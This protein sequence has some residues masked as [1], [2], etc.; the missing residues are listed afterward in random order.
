MKYGTLVPA[1]RSGKASAPRRLSEDAP[2]GVTRLQKKPGWV[3]LLVMAILAGLGLA[4]VVVASRAEAATT[5]SPNDLYILTDYNTNYIPGILKYSNGTLTT[6]VSSLGTLPT[7]KVDALGVTTSGYGYFM[8]SASLNKGDALTV[9]RVDLTTGVRQ[10]Y[11]GATIVTTPQSGWPSATAGVVDPR[12]GIYY[13]AYLNSDWGWDLY[14]FNTT[15][16]VSIGYVGQVKTSQTGYAADMAFDTAGNLY[17]LENVTTAT[18]AIFKINAANVPTVAVAVGSQIASTKV[19]SSTDSYAMGLAYLPNATKTLW[20]ASYNSATAIGYTPGVSGTTTVATLNN[21][22]ISDLA[23]CGQANPQLSLS[24]NVSGR[25]SSTDQFTLT[26]ESPAS[27]ILAS[28]TTTG[29]STGV[30]SAVAG[31]VNAT[32]GTTYTLR[33]VAAGTTDLSKYSSSAVCTRTDTGATVATS[34]SNGVFTVTYP[35]GV[36]GVS[37]ELKNL[38]P[39]TL[40][41]T[42]T[43]SGGR[44]AASDQF[45]I[46]VR[47]GGASGPA[48]STPGNETTTGTG[49]TVDPGSGTTGKFDV[50]TSTAY[51]ITEAAGLGVD[52]SQYTATISCMD[53]A[54]LQTGLPS[55][56]AFDGSTGYTLTPAQGAQ[57]RCTVDNRA[58][59]GA[60][61]GIGDGLTCEAGYVY[62]LA[63][64][65]TGANTSGYNWVYKVNTATGAATQVGKELLRT[66]GSTTYNNRLNSLAISQ[67]GLYTYYTAQRISS[68]DPTSFPIFRVDNKTQS[69]ALL[70]TWTIPSFVYAADGSSPMVR[71]GIDPTTGIYWASVSLVGAPR[72]HFFAYNTITGQNYGYVG[73]LAVPGASLTDFGTNGDL[74]FDQQG[75]M[76][77]VVSGSAKSE[78]WRLSG[79]KTPTTRT[80]LTDIDSSAGELWLTTFNTGGAN[81]V[82]FDNDGLLWVTTVSGTTSRLTAY[83]PNSGAMVGSSKAVT[84]LST[85][86][87]GNSRF[88]VDL[89]DCNDPGAISLRKNYTGR[90]NATDNVKLDITRPQVTIPGGTATTDGPATGFQDKSA[91]SV[92]GVPGVTYTLT[93]TASS[94]NLAQYATTLSCV[95]KTHGNAPV[96]VTK[97]SQGV[98]T[99]AFPGVTADDGQL[100]S[101]VECTYVNT[102]NGTLQLSKVLAADRYNDSDQFR[103]RIRSNGNDVATATTTG[104]G[105]VVTNGSTSVVRAQNTAS[106]ATQSYTFD[107]L[108]WKSGASDPTVLASYPSPTLTCVDAAGLQPAADLPTDIKLADFTSI[109]PVPGSQISCTITNTPIAPILATKKAASQVNG[110]DVVAGAPVVAGDVVTY[111]ITT[112]NSGNADGSTKLTEK[113]PVGATYTG[114]GEGWTCAATP[115]VAGTECTQTVAVTKSTSKAVTFTVTVDKPLDA[116]VKELTNAVVPDHSLCAPGD[117]TA[118]N[119]VGGFTLAK[120]AN[121]TSKSSVSA[122]DVIT[123]MVTGTNTGA[124]V[125]DP[126]AISDDFAGV[127]D[128]ADFVA[129]S[130]ASVIVHG[131]TST[132]GP[133]PSVSVTDRKLTWSGS[134]PIGARVEI[135]YQVKVQAGQGGQLVE[136]S[137]TGSGTPIIPDPANPSSPGIPGSPITPPEVGTEHPIPSVPGFDLV[138]SSDPASGSVVKAG[139]TVT[140]TVTGSNTGNTVLDPV[141]ITDD[142]SDVL[143][144][145]DL[146]AGSLSS[147]VGAVPTIS[148]TTLSWSGK[149]SVGGSVTLTYKVKVKSSVTAL[150]VLKNVAHGSATP[151]DP[152]DPTKPGTPIVPDDPTTTHPV[153]VPGFT[154]D[155]VAIPGTGTTV[156]TGDVITYQV[157]GAN[158][159]NTVLDPV[160]ITDDLSDVLDDA[161]VVNG[162]LKSSFGTAPTISGT[163]LSWKGSLPVGRSVTLTYQVMVKGTVVAGDLV[164]NKASSSATPVLPDPK[165][166]D[167]PAI[168]GTPITPPE[169]ETRHPVP[170]D[171]GFTV[172]KS[173]DPASG[174]V[175]K[176]GDVVTYTVTGSNTGNT[177]LDPVTITDNLSGVL[178]HATL[179]AGSLKST[180]G[181]APTVSGTT[182]AWTGVLPVGAHV[183]LTYAVKVT[184]PVAE[185]DRLHNTV[186]GSATPLIPDP[187]MP[188]DPGKP[189]DPITPPEVDT[190]HP[191][192]V[193][194]FALAKTSQPIPGSAVKAGDVVTYT[195]TGSNTG[196]T[197]LD[198]VTITDDLSGVLDDADLVPGSL[199]SSVGDAPVVSGAKLSWTGQ[200]AAG[201]SVRLTYKVTVK[202]DVAKAAVLKNLV[203]GSATPP[204]GGDPITPPEVVTEHPV[205][206]PGFTLTKSAAPGSGTRVSAGDTITYTVIG[207]NTGSTVLDPVRI[208]DD[209]S[210]VLDNATLIDSSLTSTVGAA[211][212]VSGDTLTWAGSLKAG[213]AVKLSYQVKVKA[214]VKVGDLVHN[215]VSGRATPIV[216]DPDNPGGPGVPGTPI[217]P[218][219]VETQHPVDVPGF[220]LAK[221]SAPG[222]GAKVSAG[223]TITYIVTGSNTGNTELNPVTITDS[224]ADVLDNAEL[225]ADSLNASVGTAKVSAGTLSWTGSLKAGQAVTITYQVKVKSGVA[226][227]AVL[228]NVAHGE[229]TP[230]GGGTPIV[231]PDPETSHPVVA[232]G[233]TVTKSSDPGTGVR[234]AAGQVITYTVTGANTGDTKLDPVTISDSLAD[235]LDDAD[236]VAGSLEAS[237]GAA[238]T[239]AGSTLTWTGA[240]GVGEHVTL[241]YQ[242][243]V[244]AEVVADA[245][246]HNTVRGTATPIVPDPK[247]PDGPGV[248]GTPIAPPEVET[249]H[250]VAVPGFILDKVADPVSGTRVFSGQVITYTVTGTNSGNTVLDPVDI[251]DDMSSVLAH[252]DLVPDSVAS[253]RGMTPTM[254]GTT[255]TWKGQLPVGASVVL[256]YQVRIR[257]GQAEGTVVKNVVHGTA[258]PPGSTPIT[259]PDVTTRHP[260]R[261]GVVEPITPPPLAFTGADLGWL[262]SVGAGLLLVGALTIGLARRRRS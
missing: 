201:S 126:V 68:G 228:R 81:G 29:T 176:V 252:A 156:H 254:S 248:P 104:T 54:G 88:T 233:F 18:S 84:G 48:L 243:K 202:N 110:K 127:L 2:G 129:N 11:T 32:A 119:P 109:T 259:P 42:K 23:S 56:A 86:A 247:N 93:E 181:S 57:L 189:G 262:P 87:D 30:Q 79:M 157:T 52:T 64:T 103:I 101:N 25:I 43:L 97:S 117:C 165:N 83:D 231:P 58:T 89:A 235:V 190:E 120:S 37:C 35:T 14:A 163:T 137:V 61:V 80:S 170:G 3:I 63:G 199:A 111:T 161:T 112:T 49:T 66:S 217:T 232:P 26:I 214:S 28:A 230:P 180:V 212:S 108:G 100:L 249:T 256:T 250:P 118:T 227:G 147:S 182:L 174:S 17:L 219:D 5:C 39:P 51:T 136:N 240:L 258:T 82:T 253:S 27:T 47:T 244:K 149:L 59:S 208:S 131:G 216:P 200:L 197:V 90:V 85:G 151:P 94:G 71:G 60:G 194:G 195:V 55:N 69:T 91:G 114:T 46:A 62:A 7:T 1:R 99:M 115:A 160:T 77:L 241:T 74:V 92:I 218:P 144:D 211:P 255:L 12:T 207:T 41:V 242:V 229:A 146:V 173:A 33:E 125:L 221:S 102:P 135:T 6:V 188:G 177:V 152:A 122:G 22:Y 73:S 169:V 239:L 184:G 234:V 143:D 220:A 192:A 196:N 130:Q 4:P 10:S 238:P 145:A 168:P 260:L 198:P 98:Y 171:P 224:L 95:D 38:P 106:G 257:S 67:G 34:G 9:Y 105:D 261:P 140:Y 186:A 70:G 225:V 159:G 162:S 183:T 128:N 124:T 191:I 31:P 13:Y 167:G 223:D 40:T 44:F 215:T 206:G 175:V 154:M 36:T 141:T 123:Y 24:K 226:K 203:A 53:A 15:T 148:G 155:K 187:S 178:N 236:L 134:L 76:M 193:P 237:R 75:N 21:Q 205:G 210:D 8:A 16:N 204:G 185:G 72:A 116:S 96:A 139:D 245:L 133:L 78:I 113:V 65:E 246:V 213:E 132:P 164:H 172:S 153:A 209:L 45:T 222:S 20:S 150:S 121:P 166:P 138:K 179:V 251:T 142:L 19:T 158:T 50:S 107:E